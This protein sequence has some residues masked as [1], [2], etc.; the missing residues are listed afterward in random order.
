MLADLTSQLLPICNEM[1]GGPEGEE[2]E[3]GVIK[4]A[5]SAL[6]TNPHPISYTC[7]RGTHAHAPAHTHASAISTRK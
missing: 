7:S 4:T 2:K 6:S 5:G 3:N 1:S